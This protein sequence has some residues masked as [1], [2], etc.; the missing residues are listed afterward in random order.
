MIVFK[1]F[2]LRRW[3]MFL[4]CVAVACGSAR[5]GAAT[6]NVLVWHRDTDTMD[7]DVEDWTVLTLMEKIA[8]ATGW[9]V[10]LDPDA[11]HPVSAKFRNRPF[12]EALRSLLGT[13]NFALV[14]QANGPS[15]LYVFRTSRSQAT[16]FIRPHPRGP[17]T[18]KPIPNQLIVRLK[19][20][21]KTKIEELAKLFGA[22]VIGRIDKLGVYQLEFDTADAAQ[23][24]L[25]QLAANPDVQSVDYNYPTNPVP[26][27]D[28]PGDAST[29]DFKLN[30]KPND[31]PCQ[32]VVG[33]IDTPVQ[34]NSNMAPFVKGVIHDAG[35]YQLSPTQPTHGTAMLDTMG[36]ALAKATG[37]T[38]STTVLLVDVYGN[39]ETTSTFDVAKG[40]TDA[41][42]G[43]ATSISA[44]LGSSG[45]SQVLRDVVSQA[46]QMGI[47][48]FAAAGN[49]PVT[50]P[51]YPAAYPGVIAV[52]ASDSSG[53]IAPY[54]NRGSFVSMIAPGDSIIP[55]DGQ[56]YL[57]EGTSTSTATVAGLGAGLADSAGDC[58]SQEQALLKQRLQSSNSIQH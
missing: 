23:A 16:Q 27:L 36:Q 12:G 30:P 13:L 58:A 34:V 37:G 4:L 56:S 28:V 44:S 55:F 40:I 10:F 49:E 2:P 46:V 33:L 54:A 26:T 31:G 8:A 39:N 35:S 5:A 47:P 22:R 51:T 7:A 52:T 14:P 17:D 38:T 1:V 45:D 6:T 29:P 24:A 18:S 43:G 41:I 48:I 15:Q 25:P 11:R 19:P 50:T 32:L 20:G 21:S 57:V 9:H 53:Q 42:N 3:W